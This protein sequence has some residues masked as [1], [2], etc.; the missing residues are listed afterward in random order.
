ML[1]TFDFHAMKAG[2]LVNLSEKRVWRCI[3][4]V[5]VG[6]CRP[7]SSPARTSVHVI[8]DPGS[9]TAASQAPRLNSRSYRA[10]V[11]SVWGCKTSILS[12]MRV[13]C[14]PIWRDARL[15]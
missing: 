11:A 10:A 9:N 6:I 8:L 4:H 7:V 2:H 3:K 1:E 13:R 12:L 5:F 15:S 14:G